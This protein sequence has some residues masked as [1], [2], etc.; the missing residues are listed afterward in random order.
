MD[1]LIVEASPMI[2]STP[3]ELYTT[4][5]VGISHCVVVPFIAAFMESMISTVSFVSLTSGT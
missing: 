5:R 1:I 2:V 3:T 4:K